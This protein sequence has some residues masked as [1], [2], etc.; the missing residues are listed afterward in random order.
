MVT[1][2]FSPAAQT[3]YI[4]GENFQFS[5]TVANS[6]LTNGTYNPLSMSTFRHSPVVTLLSDHCLQSE[7]KPTF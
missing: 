3:H 2:V 4:L 7:E 6:N 1:T 5:A